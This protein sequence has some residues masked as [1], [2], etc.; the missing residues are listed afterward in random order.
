MFDSFCIASPVRLLFTV[1]FIIIIGRIGQTSD[2]AR[3]DTNRLVCVYTEDERRKMN[4]LLEY[5]V[6]LFPFFCLCRRLGIF[7]HVRRG[8][9]FPFSFSSYTLRKGR[10]ASMINFLSSFVTYWLFPISIVTDFS[11]SF[12]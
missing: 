4:F 5:D 11:L 9:R 12:C 3:H 6:F 8:Q 7:N 10:L 1:Q 2:L